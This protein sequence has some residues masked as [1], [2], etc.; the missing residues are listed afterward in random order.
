MARGAV[1]WFHAIMRYGFI[2]PDDGSTSVRIGRD[3]AIDGLRPGA[4]VEYDTAPGPDG[5]LRAVNLRA[6]DAEDTARA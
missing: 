2:A 3:G 1:K 4:L 6:I 5:R